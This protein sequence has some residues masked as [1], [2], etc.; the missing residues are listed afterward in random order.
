MV[1]IRLEDGTWLSDTYGN[2]QHC[3]SMFTETRADELT[4]IVTLRLSCDNNGQTLL[5]GMFVRAEI[6]LY[7]MKQALTIPK[8]SVS[9]DSRN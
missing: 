5:P 1:D 4:G 2:R 6:P 7:V 8:R 9:R 3:K